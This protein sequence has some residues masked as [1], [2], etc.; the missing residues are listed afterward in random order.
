MVSGRPAVLCVALLRPAAQSLSPGSVGLWAAAS[1]EKHSGAS[2]RC[3]RRSSERC[4]AGRC[5]AV[6]GAR[7]ESGPPAP[8]PGRIRGALPARPQP[9]SPLRAVLP[10]GESRRARGNCSQT[11][12]PGSVS[13]CD[14]GRPLFSPAGVGVHEGSFYTNVCFR[15]LFSQQPCPPACVSSPGK[16]SVLGIHVSKAV[17]APAIAGHPQALGASQNVGKALGIAEAP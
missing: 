14:V 5:R 16:C 17:L 8:C 15:E 12:A 3:A 13:A 6:E 4:R 7:A 10:A 9:G 1:R 2:A 11:Q